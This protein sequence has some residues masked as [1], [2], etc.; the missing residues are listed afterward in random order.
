MTVKAQVVLL[1]LLIKHY[2]IKGYGEVDIYVQVFLTFSLVIVSGHLHAHAVF[3]SE[4][5][6][7]VPVE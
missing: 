1:C 3:S 2:A 5:N 4:N 7:P 6:P